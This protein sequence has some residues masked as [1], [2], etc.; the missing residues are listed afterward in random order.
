MFGPLDY[1]SSHKHSTYLDKFPHEGPPYL[2][3]VVCWKGWLCHASLTRGAFAMQTTLG[4]AISRVPR[5]PMQKEVVDPTN[6]EHHFECFL[7]PHLEYASNQ[8]WTKHARRNKKDTN[9]F[10]S[11]SFPRMTPLCSN[12]KQAAL[13]SV[14]C[15]GGCFAG[16]HQELGPYLGAKLGTIP[17]WRTVNM[18][19]DPY[20]ARCVFGCP[21]DLP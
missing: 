17:L 8:Y 11:F 20:N 21:V 15:F 12:A 1:P 19:S 4:L 16:S 14:H 13:G 2:A 7:F 5:T 10:V 6:I 9:S 3:E 18:G